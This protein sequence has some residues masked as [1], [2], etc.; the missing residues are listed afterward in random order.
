[1]VKAKVVAFYGENEVEVATEANLIRITV[2]EPSKARYLTP[3]GADALADLLH[4]SA[5][6]VRARWKRLGR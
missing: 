6:I 3:D 5:R 2:D 1:M 4:E